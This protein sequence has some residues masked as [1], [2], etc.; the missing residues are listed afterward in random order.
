M[1]GE[2]GNQ[3]GTQTLD[4]VLLELGVDEASNAS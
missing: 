2:T 4:F 1:N 3:T